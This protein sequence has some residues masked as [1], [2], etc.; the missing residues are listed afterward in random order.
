MGIFD[1]SKTAGSN[2][3]PEGVS[4]AEGMDPANVNN[5]Q[6]A[7]YAALAEWRDDTGGQLTTG[8]SG[9]AY[10]VTTNATV[11]SSPS[12]G[13]RVHVVAHATNTGT[14]GCTFA[15]DSATAKKIRVIT[16]EGERDLIA[17]EF[18][19][20]GHYV[21]EYD[22]SANSAAGAWILLN[23]AA[24]AGGEVLLSSASASSSAAVD[25]TLDTARYDFYTVRMYG[26]LPATDAASLLLRVSTDGGSTFV[27]TASYQRVMSSVNAD[28]GITSIAN[29]TADSEIKLA[30]SLSNTVGEQASGHVNIYRTTRFRCDGRMVIEAQNASRLVMATS[31]GLFN[32]A[33]VDAVRF[34]MSTG[35]IATG[36]FQL[37]GHRNA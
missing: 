4:I 8:G 19:I 1:W 23:P 3:S 25:F 15:P 20:A 14:S 13:V 28:T 12:D 17:G 34:L 37:F 32:S 31:A 11:P 26:V 9:T 16:S 30:D 6:R 21:L 36:T 33:V 2:T 22:D 27:S 24:P 18:K 29:S 5:D 7:Q 35:N 10:T